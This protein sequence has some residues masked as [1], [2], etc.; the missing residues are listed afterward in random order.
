[1]TPKALNWLEDPFSARFEPSAGD[2]AIVGHYVWDRPVV[3]PRHTAVIHSL[4]DPLEEKELQDLR[5]MRETH[6]TA[7]P[8]ILQELR[9]L[10]D[11]HTRHW[12]GKYRK[13]AKDLCSILEKP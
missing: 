13:A 6:I 10:I 11:K 5:A 7:D 2:P 12:R 8:A 1:M 9:E 3:I 4:E